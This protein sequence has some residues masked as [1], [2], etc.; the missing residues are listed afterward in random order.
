MRDVVLFL[1]TRLMLPILRALHIVGGKKD[2]VLLFARLMTALLNT[3]LPILRSLKTTLSDM[4]AGKVKDALTQIIDD[5]ESGYT[6]SESFGK[7]PDVFDRVVVNLIKAGECS[8]ALEV[9]FPRIV[10]YLE[11]PNKGELARV[12]HVLG[13]MT[14]SGVPI[15]EALS[16]V[17]TMCRAEKYGRLFQSVYDSIREGDTIAQ[18]FKESGIVLNTIVAMIDAGEETGDLDSALIEAAN[19]LDAIEK[20]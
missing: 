1:Y 19:L 7:H 11:Q 2:E 16:I 12:L 8:G 13:R 15:L 5:V 6:L 3:G 9:I 17:K 14:S 10:S 20:V 4:E 18:P